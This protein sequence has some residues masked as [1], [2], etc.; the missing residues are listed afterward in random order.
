MH[1]QSDQCP[2]LPQII[3]HLVGRL[4]VKPQN[5]IVKLAVAIGHPEPLDDGA[6]GQDLHSSAPCVF[7]DDGGGHCRGDVQQRNVAIGGQQRDHGSQEQEC[8][9]R[10][11]RRK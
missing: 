8:Y 1:L 7:E 5:D 4:G 2:P 3:S 11:P 9:D 10:S 6:Q